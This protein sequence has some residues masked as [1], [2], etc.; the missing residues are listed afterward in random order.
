MLPEELG[1]AVLP[2][3]RFLP[4]VDLPESQPLIRLHLLQK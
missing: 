4:V 2:F 3:R 1:V